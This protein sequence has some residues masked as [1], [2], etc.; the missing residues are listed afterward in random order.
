MPS[1]AP[2]G[3]PVPYWPSVVVK[4]DTIRGIQTYYVTLIL[5]MIFGVFALIVGLSAILI[6]VTDPA[7]AIAAAAITG[8]AACGL[9]IVFVINFIVSLMAVIRMHHGADE[10]GPEHAVNA[11]RGVLFKWIGTT[12]STLAAI[13]VVYLFLAGS[14]LLFGGPAP[15]VLYVPLL[16]TVFWTA[17]VSSKGQ[18][19][20]FMIRSL[21]PPETRR[22]S[23]L[24]S[25]L[26]PAL[27]A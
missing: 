17:G 16:V 8:S 2:A 9:V 11:R 14:S 26:I 12:L 24:A 3:L 18:M 5:D 20:R 4:P 7:S 19:Y 13:L 23:D 21:Q 22:W 15:A 6:T 27:G 25:F 10:Y 1:P